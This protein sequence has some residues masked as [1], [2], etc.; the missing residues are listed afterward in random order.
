MATLDDGTLV[1][2]AD[3]ELD[4]TTMRL[5]ADLIARD[6]AAQ[7]KL[8]QLRVSAEMVRASFADP[9]FLAVPRGATEQIERHATTRRAITRVS[10]RW[11]AAAA[12]AV[13]VAG[14]GGGLVLNRRSG[15]DEADFSQQLIDEVAGYHVTYARL[16]SSFDEIPAGKRTQIAAWLSRI[17]HGPVGVP[18]MVQAGFTFRG[19]RLLVVDGRPV[20]QLLYDRPGQPHR[21]LGLC[22]SAGEPPWQAVRITRRQGITLAAWGQRGFTFVLVGWGDANA[23]TALAA[24]L[25]PQIAAL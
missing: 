24:Q 5:V 21:P 23:L 19:A 14:F 9:A 20:G 16:D 10:L 25:H 3:G 17:L 12:M 8:R 7:E 15:S 18:D 22:I 13:G 6:P 11:A 2:F 4:A 1:A